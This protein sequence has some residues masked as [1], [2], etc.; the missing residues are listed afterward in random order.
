MHYKDK[1]ADSGGHADK[2]MGLLPSGIAGTNPAAV[3]Y[4]CLLLVLSVFR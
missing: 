4:D 3:M 2:G 1:T